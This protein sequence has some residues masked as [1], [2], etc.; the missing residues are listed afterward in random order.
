MSNSTHGPADNHLQAPIPIPRVDLNS[1][2]IID[3]F[4]LHFLFTQCRSCDDTLE[5]RFFQILSYSH[6]YVCIIYE[7]IKGQIALIPSLG[8]QNI[9]S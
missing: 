6:A 7:K 9:T 2:R 8:K 4:S 1:P 3:L 5:N